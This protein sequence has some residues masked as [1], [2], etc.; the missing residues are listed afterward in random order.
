MKDVSQDFDLFYRTREAQNSEETDGAPDNMPLVLSM[1][2]KGIVMLP[3]GLREGTRRAAERETKAK[4]RKT[5]LSP[6]E[7][8]NRKRMATVATVYSVEKHHRTAA[9]IMGKEDRTQATPRARDKRVWAS[10]EHDMSEVIEEQFREALVRDP[11]KLR[12]WIVLLDGNLSQLEIVKSMAK[13]H[14]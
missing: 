13:Q 10:L 14:S 7:K 3:S 4:N 1:D 12:P 5:R 11:D 8:R 9:Q 2:G 6:G